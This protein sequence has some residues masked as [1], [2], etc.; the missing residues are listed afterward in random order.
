MAT[1]FIFDF[2]GVCY[3]VLQVTSYDSNS[4]ATCYIILHHP[5]V[6][7]LCA[8]LLLLLDCTA[9]DV[10]DDDAAAAEIGSSV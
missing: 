6:F 3:V 9:F 4:V 10:D 2:R 5:S 8:A 7:G 1:F